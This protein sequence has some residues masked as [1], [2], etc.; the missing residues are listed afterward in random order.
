MPASTSPSNASSQYAGPSWST[1]S[2]QDAAASQP[3]ELAALGEHL[4]LCQGANRRWSTL[5]HVGNTVHG[6]AA[7]RFVTTLAVAALLIGATLLVL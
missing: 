5:R 4:S 1:S 6:F 7:S 2:F 3:M